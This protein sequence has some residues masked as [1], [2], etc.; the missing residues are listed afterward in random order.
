M[1]K[2]I[3]PKLLQ[4]DSVSDECGFFCDTDGLNNGYGCSFP[5]D[6]EG[7]EKQEPGCCFGFDCPVANEA[8]LDDLKKFDSDLYHEYKDAK[9]GPIECGSD[10]M[11]MYREAV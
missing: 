5:D 3:E 2:K 10:W 1:F 8:D 11:V 7:Y 4:L 9:Y 6:W